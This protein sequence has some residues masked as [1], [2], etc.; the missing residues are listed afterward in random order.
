MRAAY[1]QS[2]GGASGDMLLGALVDLGVSLEDIRA[3][4]DKL[5]ITGYSLSARTDVRCEIR[6]TKVHVQITNNTQMSPVE[7]LS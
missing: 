2:V 6:G 1:I 3:E 4:L 7:M 5:A